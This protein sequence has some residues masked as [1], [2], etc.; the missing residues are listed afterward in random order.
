[1]RR[2]ADARHSAVMPLTLA[3]TLAL[4][5]ALVLGPVPA[6]ARPHRRPAVFTPTV[7]LDDAR[8]TALA[9]IAGTVTSEELEREHG[10]W[11]YSFI[12]TP[13]RGRRGFVKEVNIDATSGA[14]VAVETERVRPRSRHRR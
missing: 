8:A 10:T 13:T 14:V 3:R 4:G 11:I 1:M 5:L 6:S 7:T 9:R 12:I 2:G